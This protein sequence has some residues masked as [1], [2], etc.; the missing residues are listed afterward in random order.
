VSVVQFL[1]VVYC[2]CADV[3]LGY[4][5]GRFYDRM[6]IVFWIFVRRGMSCGAIVMKLVVVHMASRSL[7]AL[8]ISDSMRFFV[9]SCW[10][11]CWWSAFSDART[12]N[13]VV[14]F[15]VRMR[16]RS[17]M[18]AQAIRRTNAVVLRNIHSVELTSSIVFSRRLMRC[19][20]QFLLAS[21]YVMVSC[22]WTMVSLYRGRRLRRFLGD[23]VRCCRVDVLRVLW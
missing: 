5:V 21:G 4:R 8:L 3:F 18:L 1:L 11:R 23:R 9:M 2:L 6:R 22:E 15:V 13:S 12:V 19:S 7:N 20:F 10:M 16:S 14:R 17:A